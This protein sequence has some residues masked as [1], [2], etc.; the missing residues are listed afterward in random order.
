MEEIEFNINDY[1][2]VKLTNYGVG[3]LMERHE[4]LKK[5]FPR[6]GEFKIELEDDGYYKIQLHN[7][8]NDFGDSIYMGATDLPFETNIILVK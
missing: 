7:L 3:L 2:K 6:L 8:M 5:V 4:K 1:V